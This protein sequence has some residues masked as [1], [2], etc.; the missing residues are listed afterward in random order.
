[1]KIKLL[2]LLLTLASIGACNDRSGMTVESTYIEPVWVTPPYKFARHGSSSVDIRHPEMVQQTIDIIY[3]NYLREARL[4]SRGIYRDMDAY[5]TNGYQ[6]QYSLKEGVSTSPKH[7][8]HR[9]I[10]LSEV[11]TMLLSIAQ[12]SGFGAKDPNLVRN[13]PIQRG[14]AG[15]IGISLG[16]KNIAFADHH[17]LVL[18]EVFRYYMMGCYYLDQLYNVHTDEANLMSEALRRDHQDHVLLTG[19]NYTAL[20]HHWD[21][22][23]GYFLRWRTTIQSEGSPLL[24]GREQAIYDAFAQARYDLTFY[25]YA[26]LEQSRKLI[27]AELSRAIVVR[28]MYLML[29]RNTQANLSEETPYAFHAISQAV[30]ILYCLP[31]LRQPS[32]EPYFTHAQVRAL[33]NELLTGD[34]LWDTERLL[35]DEQT[36]GSLRHIASAIGKPFDIQIQDLYKN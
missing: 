13:T 11:E 31:Y 19:Q 4:L 12:I 15:Y 20:E 6:Q 10:T 27:Y 35:G 1:M 32:G 24:K 25:N 2:L 7:I 28:A 29:G 26:S 3:K 21:M 30:G 14:K 16:D 34:G 17:G 22:A 5:Y 9:G 18:A 8:Q 36:A 33:I 23:Y